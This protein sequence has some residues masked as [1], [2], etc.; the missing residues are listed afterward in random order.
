[1]LSSLSLARG[2]RRTDKPPGFL[3]VSL[4]IALLVSCTVSVQ[5]FAASNKLRLARN[6]AEARLNF[7]LKEYMVALCSGNPMAAAGLFSDKA[8]VTEPDHFSGSYEQYVSQMLIPRL[9]QVRSYQL[10]VEPIMINAEPWSRI[11]TVSER[12]VWRRRSRDSHP[13][14]SRAFRHFWVFEKIGNEWFVRSLS[15]QEELSEATKKKQ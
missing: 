15:G 1:M 9:R 13:L 14:K 5:L 10:V 7:R 3:A 4:S 11:A 12:F 6:D 8:V 2:S